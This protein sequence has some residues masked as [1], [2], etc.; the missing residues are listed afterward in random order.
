MQKK[1]RSIKV[2]ELMKPILEA[3]SEQIVQMNQKQL[4]EGKKSDESNTNEYSSDKWRKYKESL[5]SYKASPYADY[6]DKGDFYD[7]FY[8]EVTN[9]GVKVGSNDSKEKKLES[10]DGKKIF[11]VTPESLKTL[12]PI[13][14]KQLIGS[15][16][17][18]I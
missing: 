3:S 4:S 9:R 2:W 6:Y 18:K 7:G 11:G 12:K 5:P 17:E 13:W 16:K 8:T 10:R 15:I 1:L 14:T